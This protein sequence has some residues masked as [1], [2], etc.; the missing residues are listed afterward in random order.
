VRTLTRPE[1]N[2]A[3]LARQLL[4]TREPVPA[5]RAIELDPFVKLG[6][7]DVAAL[8]AEARRLSERA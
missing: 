6:R 8:D 2:R 4:L 5:T 3:L 1:L 7:K